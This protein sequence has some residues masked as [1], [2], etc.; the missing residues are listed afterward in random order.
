MIPER[1]LLHTVT[2]VRPVVTAD[3][4]GDRVLDHTSSTD[5]VTMSA[6]LQQD[7]RRESY[8]LGREPLEQLW[9]MFTNVDDLAADDHVEW[10][11][12]SM[13]FTVHGPPEPT[14]DAVGFHHIEATLRVLEG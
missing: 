13:T 7:Q 14:Y 9:T 5:R 11:E 1:L 2:R 12:R 4:Y 8:D 10:P 6:R 3:T